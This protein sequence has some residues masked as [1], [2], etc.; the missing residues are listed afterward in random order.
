MTH[1]RMAEQVLL[2]AIVEAPS[3]EY[4]PPKP[5]GETLGRLSK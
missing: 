5:V 4:R 1:L 3:E 2:K